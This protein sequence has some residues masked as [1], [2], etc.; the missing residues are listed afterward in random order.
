MV[1]ESHQICSAVLRY[2]MGGWKKYDLIVFMVC[3]NI[4]SLIQPVLFYSF[5]RCL[6]FLDTSEDIGTCGNGLWVLCSE[7]ALKSFYEVGLNL[8]GYTH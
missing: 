1:E 3:S 8:S 6:K 2:L 4:G 7:V 5:H